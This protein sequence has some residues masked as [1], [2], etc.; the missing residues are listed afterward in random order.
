MSESW[1]SLTL[2]ISIACLVLQASAT[3]KCLR[4]LGEPDFEACRQILQGQ[5]DYRGRTQYTGIDKIDR[6][7]HLFH[8]FP[9][10]VQVPP[11]GVS[12][13]QYLNIEALPQPKYPDWFLTQYP[14]AV[15]EHGGERRVQVGSNSQLVNDPTP[16]SKDGCNVTLIPKIGPSGFTHDTG[17]YL[18]IAG[19]GLSINDR[20]VR[21]TDA[22]GRSRGGFDSAGDNGNLLMVLYA[23]G[24][25]FAKR[26]AATPAGKAV[27]LREA[28]A[29]E[30]TDDEYDNPPDPKRI[31]VEP[32]TGA[33]GS[34]NQVPV[35][36]NAGTLSSSI[37]SG[38]AL[39]FNGLKLLSSDSV[40]AQ[41]LV[42]F[43]NSVVDKASELL[44]AATPLVKQHAFTVG[45]VSLV[46]VGTDVI[47]W[48][49]IITFAMAMVDSTNENNPIQFASTIASQWQQNTIKAELFL[50]GK[51]VF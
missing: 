18:P 27:E 19:V 23:P 49:W 14:G 41:G 51:G 5:T 11:P 50:D 4:L 8:T 30:E 31:K 42:S 36:P 43:Y 35:G 17:K 15:P 7:S 28:E 44:K 21:P 29:D 45:A 6:K 3:P 40:T 47:Y 20:C 16:W 48:D 24:S 25:E 26:V 12:R 2:L 33:Q 1:L 34:S 10:Y 37:G 9:Q 32:G 13:T 22:G 38:W 39:E 46:L